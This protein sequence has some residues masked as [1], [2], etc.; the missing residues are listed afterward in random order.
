M[1]NKSAFRILYVARS[2]DDYLLLSTM[3]N[4]PNIQITLA[5]TAAEALQKVKLDEF[6]LF[7][8]ETRLPDGD[9]FELCR[10]MREFNPQTPIV[11]YSGDAGEVHRQKGLSV[12]ADAYLAKPYLDML[13]VTLNKF[14]FRKNL[15]AL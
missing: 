6:D 8:L 11:F 10:T 4:F 7:L 5:D 3:Y 2:E 12:G 1:K 14:I 13:T 15:S 9:G